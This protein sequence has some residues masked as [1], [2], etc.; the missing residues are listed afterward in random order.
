MFLK[1]MFEIKRRRCV[2]IVTDRKTWPERTPISDRGRVRVR[3]RSCRYP[4]RSQTK[5]ECSDS[6]Y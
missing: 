5:R 1:Q 3:A 6:R 4:S 2:H